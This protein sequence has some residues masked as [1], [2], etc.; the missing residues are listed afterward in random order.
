MFNRRVWTCFITGSGPRHAGQ[1]MCRYWQLLIRCYSLSQHYSNVIVRGIQRWPVNSLHKWPVT[2]KMFPFDDVIMNGWMITLGE[3]LGNQHLFIQRVFIIISH[4][5]IVLGD[6]SV[7]CIDRSNINCL[8]IFE[9]VINSSVHIFRISK[10]YI[11][12][13]TLCKIRRVGVW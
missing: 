4:D 5:S 8:Q 3:Q 13:I 12:L 11:S 9:T 10:S 7:I 1:Y 2:R 6:S